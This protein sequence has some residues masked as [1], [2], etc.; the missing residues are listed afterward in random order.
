MFWSRG[1]ERE[2]WTLLGSSGTSGNSEHRWFRQ[3]YECTLAVSK[4]SSQLHV[5]GI[6][7]LYIYM[8][9]CTCFSIVSHTYRLPC[10]CV[11]VYM[12][13][14]VCLCVWYKIVTKYESIFCFLWVCYRILS[15]PVHLYPRYHTGVS[16]VWR[17][18]GRGWGPQEETGSTEDQ[19]QIWKLW[20]GPAVC[21][22]V[23][24]YSHT[25]FSTVHHCLC[26]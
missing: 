12:C 25:P 11:C 16:R 15:A 8:W 4:T 22:N 7:M 9:V 24:S 20:N 2:W 21:C 5:V 6:Y 17:H 3:W 14:C 18:T 13:V 1:R 23:Y 26:V 10:V 19:R